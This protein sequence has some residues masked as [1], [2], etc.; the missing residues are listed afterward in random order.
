VTDGMSRLSPKGRGQHRGIEI[1]FEG[2][3]LCCSARYQSVEATVKNSRS[4]PKRK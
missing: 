3:V 4:S 1:V 2:R